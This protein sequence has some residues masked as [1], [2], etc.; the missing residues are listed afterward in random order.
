MIAH[1]V[2]ALL[3]FAGAADESGTVVDTQRFPPPDFDSGYSLP[4]TTT[5]ASRAELFIYLDMS[6]LL[7]TLSLSR[8][9]AVMRGWLPGRRSNSASSI[10]ATSC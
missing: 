2:V 5:P 6:L 10:S 1:A 9:F 8:W 3:A 4:L 7:I